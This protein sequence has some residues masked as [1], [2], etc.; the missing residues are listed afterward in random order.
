MG[1]EGQQVV[2]G[3]PG[4]RRRLLDWGVF[5]VEHRFLEVWR[6]YHRALSQRNSA[7][8]QSHT[9]TE[10]EVWERELAEAASYITAQR[11]EYL[12]RLQPQ[13]TG[14]M[15]KLL[16]ALDLN[17]RYRRGWP[18]GEDYREQLARA[19]R[20]D[21]KLGFTRYGPHRADLVIEA[22]GRSARD[23]LSRGQQKLVGYGL[24]L[25]QAA[26]LAEGQGRGPVILVDDLPAELDRA[27]RREVLK[28]LRTT[29]AQVFVT[30][31]DEGLLDFDDD[32]AGA[33]F[34]VEQG[35]VRKM[36]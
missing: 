21:R 22:S 20:A 25:A 31:T 2:D 1:P 24:R 23:F 33:V 11:C 30:A 14:Y 36:I 4:W 10:A 28:L 29:G 27:H 19:R 17:L 35:N 8:R 3:G 15:E 32:I 7:L 5:H 12:K 6:R 26:L 34:H 9:G 13:F 16:P 18:E